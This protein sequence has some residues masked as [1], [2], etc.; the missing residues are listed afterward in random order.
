MNKNIVKKKLVET[1][2][3][4]FSKY[5]VLFNLVVCVSGG[6]LGIVGY[7][8]DISGLLYIGIVI[9]ISLIIEKRKLIRTHCENYK[10]VKP[11]YT[12]L[13]VIGIPVIVFTV[14]FYLSI[15]SHN[16][17][18]NTFNFVYGIAVFLLALLVAFNAFIIIYKFTTFKNKYLEVV[19]DLEIMVR[20]NFLFLIIM[21][22]IS[23]V[24]FVYKALMIPT[25]VFALSFEKI[26]GWLSLV[27]E[28]FWIF[29][30]F[31]I[32]VIVGFIAIYFLYERYYG[33]EYA[34]DVS[35]E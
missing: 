26:I 3:G 7:I 27:D 28:V 32:S 14:A 21:A 24:E 8:Y 22:L 19:A 16:V 35:G 10:Q 2:R 5:F 9:L 31:V 18:V 13:V 34:D 30:V 23:I 15:F 25:S 1:F 6:V 12:N 33:F 11:Y 29:T 4:L 20:I 17:I